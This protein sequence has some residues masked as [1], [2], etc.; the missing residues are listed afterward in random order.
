MAYIGALLHDIGKAKSKGVEHAH[1]GASIAREESIHPGIIHIIESHIGGGITKS[2]AKQ[3]GFPNGE[4]MPK[5][6]EAKI[7]SACDNLFNGTKRQPISKRI[8][9]LQTKKLTDASKRTERLHK[10]VSKELG[11]DLDEF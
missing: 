5:T 1:I 6:K 9:W 8:E 4:Y 11:V 7:V 10:R 3:L 2:E